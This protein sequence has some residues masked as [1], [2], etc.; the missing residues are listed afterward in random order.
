[1]SMHILHTDLVESILLHIELDLDAFVRM[2]WVCMAWREV[3]RSS[4]A[5]LVGVA[6]RLHP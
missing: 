6:A 2:G 5:L 1:M 4:P 3:C